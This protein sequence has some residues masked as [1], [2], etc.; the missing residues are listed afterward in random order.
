M[1]PKKKA[2]KERKR[3][4]VSLAT[5]IQILDRLRSGAGSTAFGREFELGESTVRGIKKIE[6]KIRKSVTAGAT[7]TLCKTSH[8]RSPLFEKMEKMLNIWIEDKN[9]RHLPLSGECIRL[10]AKRI[11]EEKNLANKFA[12]SKSLVA[13]SFSLID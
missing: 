9:Q 3:K 5:K 13:W 1:A 8:A 10:K 6:D 2:Q 11:F 7:V 4:S 12:L